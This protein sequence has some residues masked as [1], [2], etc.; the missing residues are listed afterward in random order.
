MR[1]SWGWKRWERGRK[2]RAER[3]WESSAVWRLASSRTKIS[4][5]SFSA[6]LLLY[7]YQSDYDDAEEEE[8]EFVLCI[9][10]RERERERER[11]R[12]RGRDV[13]LVVRKE[14]AMST[15]VGMNY[16][17]IGSE[18]VTD[19]FKSSHRAEMQ[20]WL[21]WT[22]TQ[23]RGDVSAVV[24]DDYSLIGLFDSNA[25]QTLTPNY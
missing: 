11:K 20:R 18:H 21:W 2:T 8:I 16:E 15:R 13:A 24:S 10:I 12:A 14:G 5:V 9:L 6:S 19:I 3:G 25:N 1:N 22:Q 17:W 23:W 4:R 7:Q